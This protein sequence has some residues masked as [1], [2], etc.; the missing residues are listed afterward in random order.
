MKKNIIDIEPIR[1]LI[2]NKLLDKYNNTTYMNTSTIDIRLDI[3]DLLD[4]YIN[5]H[6]L[7]EPTVYITAEAYSKMR[8]LVDDISSEVGWYGTVT[9][10]PMLESTY[11]IEDILVYPQIVTGATVEQDEDR[12]F[13]F[14][15]ELTNEQVNMKR[16]H[17]HS[18]VNMG[19]TP[20]G[21]DEQFYK[22]L[23]TQVNDFFIVAITNKKRDLYVRFYDIENNIL[24]T[25]V[26]LTIIVEDGSTL[27]IWYEVNKEQIKTKV[28]E[29]KTAA[30]LAKEAS[31]KSIF[32]EDDWYDYGYDFQGYYKKNYKKGRKGL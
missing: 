19:V 12:M 15:M 17:G 21:V 25:D 14:E 20:S 8:K 30:E 28:T 10:V 22:D 27:D 2:K 1:E 6:D 5:E 18:H 11:V 9:K 32:D 26:P 3:K 7:K 24:Y 13:E 16:F 31:Q 29:S 4:A 23:L